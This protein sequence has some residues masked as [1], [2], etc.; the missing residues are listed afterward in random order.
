MKEEEEE[1]EMTWNGEDMGQSRRILR[2][3][4]SGSDRSKYIL[5]VYEILKE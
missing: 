4:G 1:E 5:F 2:E 3:D